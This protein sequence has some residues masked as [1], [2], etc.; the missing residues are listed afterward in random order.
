MPND[1]FLRF[2]AILSCLNAFADTFREIS[3]FRKIWKI[4]FF[5]TPDPGSLIFS[6]TISKEIHR[7]SVKSRPRSG[8]KLFFDDLDA[9]N[10]HI[11]MI[12]HAKSEFIFEI[13]KFW[14][15]ILGARALHACARTA[16][17]CALGYR[18][19]NDI[20]FWKNSFFLF[21]HRI[22][23]NTKKPHLN[24]KTIKKT[25]SHFSCVRHTGPHFNSFFPFFSFSTLIRI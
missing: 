20:F 10:T 3:F 19:K 9:G 1:L 22:A 14:R 24:H 5:S 11:T 2:Y 8:R 25:H 21:L 18:A 17:K 13:A 23:P 7:F 16:A 15:A 6:S 12:F 4:S